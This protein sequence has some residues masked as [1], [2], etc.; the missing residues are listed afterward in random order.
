MKKNALTSILVAALLLT[1]CSKNDAE[2]GSSV[3]SE[4]IAVSDVSE[5]ESSG[6]AQSEAAQSEQQEESTEESIPMEESFD[7]YVPN[8]D[9][10][11]TESDAKLSTDKTEYKSGE[12]VTGHFSGTDEKDWIGF[13]NETEG[14]GPVPAIVWK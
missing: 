6:E 11:V 9:N 5:E 12:N 13:Y 14:P 7:V 3:N 8:P 10:V 2:Q 1:A 4:P